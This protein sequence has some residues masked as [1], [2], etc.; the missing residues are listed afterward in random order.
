VK[1]RAVCSLRSLDVK[2]F[3]FNIAH[4]GWHSGLSRSK[5]QEYLRREPGSEVDREKQD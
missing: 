4:Y 3:P 1:R 5:Q 2:D